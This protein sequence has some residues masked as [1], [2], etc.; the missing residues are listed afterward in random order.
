MSAANAATCD[1]V[2]TGT[3][4]DLGRVIRSEH[5]IRHARYELREIGTPTLED[6]LAPLLAR[7]KAPA[8]A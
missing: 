8:R 4:F 3:P 1:V 6:V 7:K 5:P 2:V